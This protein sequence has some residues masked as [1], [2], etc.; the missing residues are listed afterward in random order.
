VNNQI[1]NTDEVTF[2]METICAGMTKPNCQP[3]I[4]EIS[5]SLENLKI[6]HIETC[7]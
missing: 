3:S 6:T 4:L 2:V 7:C 5:R 1:I